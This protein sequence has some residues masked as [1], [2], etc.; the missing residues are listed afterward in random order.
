MMQRL[1]VT[2][3]RGEATKYITHLDMMRFFER[4]FR[5]ARLPLA[6]SQGFHP[7]L[8][9]ALAAPMPVGVTGEAELMDVFLEEPVAP[10]DFL[11][12]LSAQM[13][14]GFSLLTVEEVEAEGPSLQA[15]MRYADYNVTVGSDRPRKEV[16]ASIRALMEAESFPWEHLRDGTLKQYDLRAQVAELAFERDMDD[17]YQLRMR[18][19]T[20]S[21]AAGRP[22]QVV[23]ALGFPERPLAI[24][25]VRLILDRDRSRPRTSVPATLR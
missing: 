8:R 19:Q 7:H 9:F 11:E 25:R 1:R 4:A 6:R 21:S 22:E 3:A 24:H 15:L 13:V 5:R 17:G 18:L 2:F 16:E 12:R 23:R 10:E 14:P 20:D